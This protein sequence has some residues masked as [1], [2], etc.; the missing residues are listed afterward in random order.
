[1][2][3]MMCTFMPHLYPT[4]TICVITMTHEICR[5]NTGG[6][7]KNFNWLGAL[8]FRSFRLFVPRD[9]NILLMKVD[10]TYLSYFTHWTST[11]ISMRIEDD[12]P[13]QFTP[14]YCLSYHRK[15]TAI[16]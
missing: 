5:V 1:M 11:T 15:L 10:Y 2:T 7:R 8:I 13:N 4:H 16:P 3:Q 12:I 6:T 9:I 14:N